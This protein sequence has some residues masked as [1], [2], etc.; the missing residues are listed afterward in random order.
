M[1]SEEAA[2][3]AARLGRSVREGRALRGWSQSQLARQ[4]AVG[5]TAVTDLEQGRSREPSFRVVREIVEALGMD[6]HRVGRV[7]APVVPPRA[8]LAPRRREPRIAPGNQNLVRMPK[9]SGR[10]GAASRGMR[11]ILA[12][13]VE[14]V[15]SSGNWIAVED[16]TVKFQAE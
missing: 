9:V 16:V 14:T 4:S 12:G 8:D 15:P 2:M 5:L 1:P 3:E 7:E 6:L 10:F 11:M 13:R